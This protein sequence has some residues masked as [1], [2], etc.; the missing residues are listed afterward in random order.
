MF[1]KDHVSLSLFVFNLAGKWVES[2]NYHHMLHNVL[3]Q[4]YFSHNI[5]NKV[6][7][8]ALVLNFCQAGQRLHPNDLKIITALIVISKATFFGCGPK[9]IL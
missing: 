3:L 2:F 9:P 8:S 4:Y 7:T 6:H 1:L 5:I